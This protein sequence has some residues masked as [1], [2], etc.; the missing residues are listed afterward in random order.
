MSALMVRN[1]TEQIQYRQ[2]NKVYMRINAHMY[3]HLL[4]TKRT[5]KHTH[6]IKILQNFSSKFP[7]TASQVGSPKPRIIS[8]ITL[9]KLRKGKASIITDLQLTF[10]IKLL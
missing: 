9:K 4:E 5:E 10:I 2:S 8:G 6:L 1:G 3:A 7:E